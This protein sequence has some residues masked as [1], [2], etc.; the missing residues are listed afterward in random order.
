MAMAS[1]PLGL[2]NVNSSAKPVCFL[3][4]GR[5]FFSIVR[6][7][8]LPALALRCMETSR[9]YMIGSPWTYGFNRT[10]LNLIQFTRLPAYC[11]VLYLS[12]TSPNCCDD[13]GN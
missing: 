10:E 12:S 3:S 7:N 4:R 13:G 6:V 1:L 5:M 9:A 8:S 2:S 11:D